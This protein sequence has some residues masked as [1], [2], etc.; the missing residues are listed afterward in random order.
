MPVLRLYKQYVTINYSMPLP[1]NANLRLKLNIHCMTWDI[2]KYFCVCVC[3]CVSAFPGEVSPLR[4]FVHKR[5]RIVGGG[6]VGI[7]DGSWMV[8]IQKGYG[9]EFNILHILFYRWRRV[10]GHSVQTTL[11]FIKNSVELF[12]LFLLFS[13]E[14]SNAVSE[15]FPLCSETPANMSK[16]GVFV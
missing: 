2:L 6:P 14:G 11:E 13:L 1:V 16:L 9:I 12:C 5:T 7:S 8:S 10:V 4:C 15:A 3:V